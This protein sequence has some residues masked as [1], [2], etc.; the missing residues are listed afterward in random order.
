MTH[1]SDPTYLHHQY[2][3]PSNLD[4]RVALHQLYST[5]PQG[6]NEWVLNQFD[7]PPEARILELGCGPGH[8]WR[9][10]LERLPE[11]WRIVLSDLSRGMVRTARRSLR[12]VDHAGERWFSFTVHDAQ[13]L[14]Y[15]D[16]SFDAV[17]ANHMLYHVPNKWHALSEIYRG[18]GKRFR[19]RSVDNVIEEVSWVQ[20]HYPLE[21][22]VFVDDTFVLSNEWLAE[23]AEEYPR[24]IGI[25][26]F[27][28]SR[29]NLV[30]E[31]Q[32]RLLKVAGCHTVSMGIEVANDEI[33][34]GLLKRRM[35]REQILEADEAGGPSV[36]RLVPEVLGGVV[37]D[38]TSVA[39]DRDLIGD[40]ERLFA[41]VGHV[42][43][44]R[45]DGG[46][47]RAH[48]DQEVLTEGAVK[49]S[50]WFIQEYESGIRRQRACQSDPLLFSSG[51]R[52]DGAVLVAGEA[53]QVEHLGH[54]C[55]DGI[56]TE[57]PHLEAKGDV[58]RYGAVR[59]QGI[60][61]EHQPE[62][63]PVRRDVHQRLAI[64]CDVARR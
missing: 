45:M 6:W 50:E 33:R 20:E 29:A 34:N 8:L 25:P 10:N 51:E 18:K 62:S 55:A 7:L 48:L 37:G 61:L 53:H 38:D 59:E 22:V 17:V 19:L 1:A 28:N 26:F 36:G 52:A 4:A 60:V 42:E 63:A 27:C 30:T 56:S 54:A 64:P 58:S 11:G 39:D 14:P 35:S 12:I 15:P 32:V 16:G 23:F 41:V 40:S 5:H 21:H 9:S 57:A 49:G 13:T 46:E 3:D 43:D 24:R 2:A 31:E 47:D 44:G